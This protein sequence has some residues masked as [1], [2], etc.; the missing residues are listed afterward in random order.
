MSGPRSGG[1]KKS[2]KN[3]YPPSV[4]ARLPQL[5]ERAGNGAEG[6]RLDH[7]VLHRPQPRGTITTIRSLMRARAILDGHVVLSRRIAESGHY[8]AIDI[9]ASVSRAMHE[10]AS[11]AQCRLRVNSARRSP[12][13]NKTVT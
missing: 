4:F 2:Q 6:L 7:G 8:P 5:V 13:I 1:R 10:I 9:E 12:L 11:P 3:S